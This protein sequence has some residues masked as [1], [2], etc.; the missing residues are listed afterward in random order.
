MVNHVVLMGRVGRDPE[1]RTSQK[2]T[3]IV[4]LSMATTEKWGTGE[5]RKEQTE[6]HNLVAFGKLADN[7]SRFVK[8]GNRLY[9]SGKIQTRKWDDKEG[10]K[11]ER[12]EIVCMEAVFIDFNNDEKRKAADDNETAAYETPATDGLGSLPF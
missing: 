4:T 7:I 2:G 8:K 11:H 5:A 12:V 6:W 9:V 10:N 1:L 3:A